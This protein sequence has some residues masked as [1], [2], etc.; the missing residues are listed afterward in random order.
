MPI[1]KKIKNKKEM[2]KRKEE[3]VKNK[4]IDLYILERKILI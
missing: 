2:K 1:M 4:K 3:K